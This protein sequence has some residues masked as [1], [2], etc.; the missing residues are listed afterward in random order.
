MIFKLPIA[1][2]AS[3]GSLL[4]WVSPKR[5]SP[6]AGGVD[7][8]DGAPPPNTLGNDSPG[9]ASGV[10]GGVSAGGRDVWRINIVIFEAITRFT[11]LTASP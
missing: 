3:T 1:N 2:V 5:G 8:A 11:G 6:L 4:D 10:A 9:P 7:V